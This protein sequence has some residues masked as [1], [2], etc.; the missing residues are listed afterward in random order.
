MGR[1]QANQFGLHDM[2]GNVWEWCEDVYNEDFYSTA[3]A[4]GPDPVATSGGSGGRVIRG[5]TFAGFARGARSASRDFFI[6]TYRSLFLGFR[7]ARPFP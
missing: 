6:P 7:P 3:E 5:G 2:H 1:K 4:H